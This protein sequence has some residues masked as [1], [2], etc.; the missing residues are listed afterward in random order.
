MG[1]GRAGEM[2]RWGGGYKYKIQYSMNPLPIT[3]STLSGICRIIGSRLPLST[4]C[5]I[6]TASK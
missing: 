6:S 1:F 5:R 4:I 3:P 2:G